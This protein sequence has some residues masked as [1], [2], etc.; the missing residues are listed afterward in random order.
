MHRLRDVE[1][2]RGLR[3]RLQSRIR[4]FP[5]H[6]LSVA[7]GIPIPPPLVRVW[8]PPEAAA[9]RCVPPDGRR[10]E[11]Q[12]RRLHP[13]PEAPPR[14]SSQEAQSMVR[15]ALDPELRTNSGRRTPNSSRR[16]S[17]RL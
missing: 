15:A 6:L 2:R 9:M 1:Y 11:V 7:D 4:P 10:S 16:L 12:S 17:R 8:T 13:L 3:L 14:R 5:E